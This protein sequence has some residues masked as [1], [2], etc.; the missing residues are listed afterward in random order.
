M[1]R[2][3]GQLGLRRQLVP[4]RA[5]GRVGGRRHLRIHVLP[6]DEAVGRHEQQRVDL[7]FL[8]EPAS[9]LRRVDRAELHLRVVERLRRP[10]QGDREPRGR[11]SGD[12][13]VE[14]A[15]RVEEPPDHG[16]DGQERKDQEG[17]GD[18]GLAAEP[19][20]DLARG[21]EGYRASAT[22]RSTSSRKSSA[23]D[24]GP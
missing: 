19:L 10:L 20:A 3:R 13:V 4:N 15:L 11:G 22:H 14:R 17:R 1:Q 6:E 18:E 7:A 8:E 24:G 12:R 23:S 16:G 5:D 21:D 2:G 9:S